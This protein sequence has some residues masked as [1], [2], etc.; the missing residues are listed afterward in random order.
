MQELDNDKKTALHHAA[1]NNASPE[2]VATL[3]KATANSDKNYYRGKLSDRPLHMKDNSGKLPLHVA[4]ESGASVHVV[5]QLLQA[6]PGS[7]YPHPVEVQS[8][9]WVEFGGLNRE[10]GKKLEIRGYL[11]L[12]WACINGAS[13][14]VIDRLLVAYPDAV[15]QTTHWVTRPGFYEQYTEDDLSLPFHLALKSFLPQSTL[16]G[17]GYDPHRNQPATYKSFSP[18]RQTTTE[19]ITRLLQEYPAAVN[20]RVPFVQPHT[21]Y[22]FSGNGLH[23]AVA[24]SV[25]LEV[26]EEILKLNPLS[27]YD[28]ALSADRTRRIRTK[29]LKQEDLNQAFDTRYFK[30]TSVVLRQSDEYLGWDSYLR[31]CDPILP[32]QVAIQHN[33]PMKVVSRLL[34]LHPF[35]DL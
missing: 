32:V 14:D 13:I 33:A 5:E 19:V 17:G 22:S 11:P 1:G 10:K 18:H 31:T 2:V 12:H 15:N 4:V 24:H 27:V 21:D 35:V 25:S 28:L 7:P 3:L 20:Y 6:N 34:E 16:P 23:Y 26:V 8:S 30:H 9:V 29:E